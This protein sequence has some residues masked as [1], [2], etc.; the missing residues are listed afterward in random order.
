MSLLD[1]ALSPLVAAVQDGGTTATAL[2]EEALTRAEQRN[3]SINAICQFNPQVLAEADSI[4]ARLQAG[5]NLPLAG[6]PVLIKD[7]IWVEGMR[8]AQG[9]RLF[10]DHIAPEDAEAVKRLRTAGAVIIG[11]TTCSEFGCKGAT[12]SPLH[13]VTRNPVD[14]KLGPGGSSGGS[15]AAVAAGIVPLA[16][17]T[18]AGGSSRRPP[19]HTGVCGFKPTQDLI[20]Y[21]A[22]FDEPVWGISAI[23]PIARCMEDIALAM[24]ALAGLEPA[25][26]PDIEIAMSPD[27]GTAQRLDR[28]VAANFEAV[29]STLRA[30][31]VSIIQAQIDWPGNIK[32]HDVLPLQFAGL[33]NL[34]ADLWRETP[35]QFD[36]AIARQI[37]TGLTLSGVDVSKAHQISHQMRAT[38]RAALD[39]YDVIATPTTPCS[40][41]SAEDNAPAEIGGEPAAMRDHAAFTP[42]I[43]H[44]GVPALS[45]PCGTDHQGRPLGLQLVAQIGRDAELIAVAQQLQSILKEIA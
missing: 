13:G 2:A 34:Y 26:T 22:S 9:S 43:N 15:A 25:Q 28:E 23:C 32:G 41:W 30:A 40:A 3:P 35:E 14:L 5:E 8:I 17:G 19:A 1:G 42:Q 44:A 36:P 4:S 12:N 39:Q 21:G 31:G 6:V 11:I 37:E 45:L 33:A 10:A 16:L 29:R 24:R 7:N 20:P 38:L 18:D 27:F